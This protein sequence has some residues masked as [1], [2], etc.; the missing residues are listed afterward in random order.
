MASKKDPDTNEVPAFG[1]GHNRAELDEKLREYRDRVIS[2]RA[3]REAINDDI[4]EI[5]SNVKALGITKKAFDK[6]LAEYLMDP[7]KR[8]EQQT[9]EEILSEAWGM[10]LN[11]RQ[12]DMFEEAA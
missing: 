9:S 10:P 5:R 1:K 12:D 6:K 8:E 2:L 7:D 4:N 11:A 3:D